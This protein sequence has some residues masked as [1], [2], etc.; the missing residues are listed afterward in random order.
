MSQ[1]IEK[2]IQD[3]AKIHNISIGRDDPILIL[4]TI[5]EMLL[6]RATEAQENQLKAFQEEIQL[7]MKQLSEESKDKAEKVISAA[8]NASRANIERAT[9]EQI[10]SFNN[11]LSK[12]LNGSLIEF[13][14]ILSNESAKGM[15]LAKFSMIASIFALASSVIVALVTLL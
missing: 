6:K 2:V 3:I 10:D 8:L 1:E 5:N 15:Q 9:S 12:T 4:Y 11:Q 7:S 13:K 14:T